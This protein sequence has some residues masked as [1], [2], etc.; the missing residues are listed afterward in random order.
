MSSS[1]PKARTPARRGADG[2]QGTSGA[3]ELI[4]TTTVGAAVAS[5]NFTGLSSTYSKYIIEYEEVQPSTDGVY[6]I[7]RTSADNGSTYDATAGHYDWTYNVRQLNGENSTQSASATH[8]QILGDVT[9]TGEHMGNAANETGSG[10]IEIYRPEASKFTM[11][12]SR[13]IY[14]DE[15]SQYAYCFSS[16]ARMSAAPV[17]AVRLLMSSGNIGAGVFKLYGVR[18]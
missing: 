11:I 18:A 6:L 7:F 16:G 9:F 1:L 4:S 14:C 3:I 12:F 17:N 10:R 8:I 2:A 5:V 15:D 13:G